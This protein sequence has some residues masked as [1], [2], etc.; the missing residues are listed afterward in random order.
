MENANIREKSDRPFKR[1]PRS[2]QCV[3]IVFNRI[4]P[5]R[6]GFE[7]MNDQ[8]N[9]DLAELTRLMLTGDERLYIKKIRNI[10]ICADPFELSE[11]ILASDNYMFQ[12]LL[13]YLQL[14]RERPEIKEIV[15]SPK[16][17]IRAL[18]RIVIHFHQ[19]CM[20]QGR[21]IEK[22]F[23]NYFPLLEQEQYFRLITE[24]KYIPRDM[25]ICFNI[26]TKLDKSFLER[27]FNE[28][29]NAVDFI[30][31]IILG[32]SEELTREFFCENPDLYQ[33]FKMYVNHEKEIE[34]HM[35]DYFESN[36]GYISE[37]NDIIRTG[38]RISKSRLPV[39]LPDGK[40]NPERITA[41]I[42]EIKR[43][44]NVNR[45]MQ[46]LEKHATYYDETEMLLVRNILANPY[47]KDILN[48]LSHTMFEDLEGLHQKDVLFFDKDSMES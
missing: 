8:A 15:N 13:Y 3:I 24:T 17:D 9:N 45:T 36:D 34:S 28:L 16:F 37:A 35:G 18:E 1:L 26:L 5:V 32:I 31:G 22:I 11:L 42:N 2:D 38:Q 48:N 6:T 43:T 19:T 4:K 47:F 12:S 30:N 7:G 25:L 27:F 41:I 40:R 33:Y 20:L 46:Y 39:F 29:K 10:L 44:G 23:T 14:F 21:S